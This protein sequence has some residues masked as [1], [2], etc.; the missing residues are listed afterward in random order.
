MQRC[1]SPCGPQNL[2]PTD[3]HVLGGAP[4]FCM[5]PRLIACDFH[6]F[7]LFKKSL[8]GC[9]FVLNDKAVVE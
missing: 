4:K 6:V 5:H 3:C 7:G 2:G 8:G 9:M 1:P